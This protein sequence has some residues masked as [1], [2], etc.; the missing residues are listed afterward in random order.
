MPEQRSRYLLVSCP[1]CYAKVG[2]RCWSTASQS[3]RKVHRGR[4]LAADHVK[5][6]AAASCREVAP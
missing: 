1:V 2:R 3:Y 5:E 6:L 4:V